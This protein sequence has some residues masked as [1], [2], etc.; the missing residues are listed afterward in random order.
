MSTSSSTPSI[1]MVLTSHDE[2]GDTGN[3]TGFWLEELAAPYYAFVDAGAEVTL[4]SPAGGRPP[5][6]PS[7]DEDDAQ[8]EATERFKSD[9]EAQNR[10]DST[11]QLADIDPA[12]YDAVFFPGGHGPMWDLATSDTAAELLSRFF[13]D[14]KPVGAVCHGPAVF[15]SLPP[16]DARKYLGDKTL[17]AFTNTE[18]A[19]VGLADVVPFSLADELREVAAG[20]EHGK[21]W[22][23]FV[24]MDDNL[25]TGQ[26]PASS[27]PAAH[28]LLELLDV[29]SN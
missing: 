20:F 8:T 3:K 22:E 27:A 9:T 28:A 23:S 4:A 18:E 14:G 10:L 29:T 13:D 24:I 16:Q 21:N 25:V 17:T 19:A 26:N 6:D 2:L 1:L 11:T 12:D 7:S 15:T 5:L